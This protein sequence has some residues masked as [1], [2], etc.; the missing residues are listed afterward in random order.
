MVSISKAALPSTK[1][2]AKVTAIKRN[3]CNYT[4]IALI[5]KHMGVLLHRAGGKVSGNS[6][7][8]GWGGGNGGVGGKGRRVSVV[9]VAVE[10]VPVAGAEAAETAGLVMRTGQST[11]M[12]AV[13]WL[14][15]TLGSL[16]SQLHEY[17]AASYSR[18]RCRAGNSS[19]G[20]YRAVTSSVGRQSQP[21]QQQQQKPSQPTEQEQQQ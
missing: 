18:G 8:S 16:Q 9:V 3:D 7:S 11:P 1:T 2:F 13:A 4:C 21:Q 17:R 14:L 15:A 12:S 19:G 10:D 20:R 6:C 5:Y